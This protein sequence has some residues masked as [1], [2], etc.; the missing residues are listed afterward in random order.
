[1]TSN[2]KEELTAAGGGL[3]QEARGQPRRHFGQVRHISL[4]FLKLNGIKHEL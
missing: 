1:L 2:L 3:L 4:T